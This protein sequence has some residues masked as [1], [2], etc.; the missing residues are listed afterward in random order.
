MHIFW[1]NT[2]NKQTNKQTKTPKQ[3]LILLL[4]FHTS[5]MLEFNAEVTVNLVK[6]FVGKHETQVLTPDNNT[7][8][9][10]CTSNHI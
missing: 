1:L 2:K 4:C 3:T 5:A 10:V 6:Y 9:A 7:G 8:I